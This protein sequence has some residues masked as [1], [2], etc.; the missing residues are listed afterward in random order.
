[1]TERQVSL[2]ASGAAALSTMKPQVAGIVAVEPTK[3][4]QRFVPRTDEWKTSWD[5]GVTLTWPIFDGGK[6]RADNAAALAQAEALG[7]RLDD[8]D[9][10]LTVE[11]RQRLLDLESGRAALAASAEAVTAATEARRVVQERFR[12]GVATST[13]VLDAQQELLEAELERTRLAATQRLNEA[14]LVRTVGGR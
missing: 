7:H 11:V 5:L 2:R 3:P 6:A 12:A 13:E 1:L 10:A 14:E 8:F 4:N 9:L